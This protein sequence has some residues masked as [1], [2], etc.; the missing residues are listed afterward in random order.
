MR[1]RKSKKTG[2]SKMNWMKVGRWVF[3]IVIA[4]TFIRGL[5]TYV[6][7]K[8]ESKEKV[9]TP[10][11]VSVAAQGFATSFVEDYLTYNKDNNNT[12]MD[13][14]MSAYVASDLENSL[15]IDFT[16]VS[17]NVNVLTANVV[18][19]KQTS[20]NT[21]NMVVKAV[22]EVKQPYKVQET[23]NEDQP[24]EEEKNKGPQKVIRYVQVPLKYEKNNLYVYDYPSFVN[25]AESIKGKMVKSPVQS[26]VEDAVLNKITSVTNDFFKT[27]SS[28][29]P[30]QLAIYTLNNKK[31]NG[32]NG[33]LEFDELTGINVVKVQN[34]GGTDEV[35]A[36]SES[37]WT[38]PVSGI[39][40]TQHHYFLFQ[41]DADKWL[42]KEFEGGWN[43]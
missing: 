4:L 27:Y 18:D 42:I 10:Y 40:T 43:N 30:G 32:Y 20:E 22:L 13:K 29:T 25:Y 11:I 3:W 33:N 41:K 8:A 35:K 26:D 15:P 28:G 21:S 9:E 14:R 31:I 23:E 37:Q 1:I 39:K 36:Y 17:S 34:E 7:H 6:P 5:G 2:A 16:K 24:V 19:F 12:D 38:D